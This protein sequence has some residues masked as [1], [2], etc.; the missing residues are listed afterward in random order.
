MP[1]EATND[2]SGLAVAAVLV[3]AT[4][5]IGRNGPDVAV[6]VATVSTTTL[7]VTKPSY[8]V[9]KASSEEILD[10]SDSDKACEYSED[11]LYASVAYDSYV[12]MALI[13]TLTSTVY[14]AADKD[15]ITED[16]VITSI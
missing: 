15:S 8:N 6:G 16:V 5:L 1:S 11:A 7:C 13:G 12:S 14:A 2:V 10:G 9:A 4:T 3:S